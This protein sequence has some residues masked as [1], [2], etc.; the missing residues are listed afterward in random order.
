MNNP[1][2]ELQ[3]YIRQYWPD[4]AE[5]AGPQLLESAAIASLSGIQLD[6]VYSKG[7]SDWPLLEM[8]EALTA[9]CSIILVA[10]EI[11]KP[12]KDP[13]RP[14]YL[15]ATSKT[16]VH[17]VTSQDEFREIKTEIK[18]RLPTLREEIQAGAFAK[19]EDDT[20]SSGRIRRRGTPMLPDWLINLAM[21]TIFALGM[22]L[23]S[24]IPFL[25]RSF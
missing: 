25:Q 20:F 24:A 9:I 3:Q 10:L 16:R 1:A 2:S 17:E 11:L 15:E 22:T 4:E 8:A 13:Q 6:P 19:K 14:A 21:G 5:L 12:R 23:L 7:G 18:F